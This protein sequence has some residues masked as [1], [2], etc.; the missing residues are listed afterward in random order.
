MKKQKLWAL[1]SLGWSPLSRMLACR[2]Q[3]LV[4]SP[5][6]R[7]QGMVVCTSKSSLREIEEDR[8]Q[9]HPQLRLQT[10][11][12]VILSYM[13]A[14]LKKCRAREDSKTAQWVSRGA[15]FQAW[16]PEFKPHDPQHQGNSQLLKVVLWP[17]DMCC[18][19]YTPPPIH[20]HTDTQIK[21]VI[22]TI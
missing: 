13:W 19:I 8:V 7:K 18:G 5:A 17:L 11:S 15:C 6:L 16:L 9:G 10:E 4:W 2:A 12:K 14:C 3:T 21:N 1:R 20:T 22:K